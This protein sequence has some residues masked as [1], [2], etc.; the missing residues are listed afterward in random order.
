MIIREGFLDAELLSEFG[1][2]LRR[3][4]AQR[5]QFKTRNAGD[6]LTMYFA[7]PTESN[8]GNS[9]ARHTAYFT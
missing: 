5:S 2:T 4:R 8:D 6:R 1:Q 9:N 7:E 3:S